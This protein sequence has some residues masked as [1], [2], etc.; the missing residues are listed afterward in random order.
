MPRILLKVKRTEAIP[1]ARH[2]SNGVGGL[3][4]SLRFRMLQPLSYTTQITMHNAVKLPQSAIA[5]P[6]GKRVYWRLN[7]ARNL[8]LSPNPK[9]AFRYGKYQSSRVKRLGYWNPQSTSRPASHQAAIA[10]HRIRIQQRTRQAN[11]QRNPRRKS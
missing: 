1:R 5:W 3:T 11:F 2:G 6:L 4:R 8:Q 7:T 9:G 10:R